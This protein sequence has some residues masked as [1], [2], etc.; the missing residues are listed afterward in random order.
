MSDQGNVSLEA[1]P[2]QILY[3]N[4]LNKGMLI[5]LAIL[6]SVA[7]SIPMRETSDVLACCTCRM[8]SGMMSVWCRVNGLTLCVRRRRR[9][10]NPGTFMV[11]NSG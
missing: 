9:L 3:A 6:F 11:G 4:L 8:V 10:Q 7:R 1:T 2:E 5:G